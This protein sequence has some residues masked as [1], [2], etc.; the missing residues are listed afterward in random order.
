MIE[1]TTVIS[2]N[3]GVSQA[4]V[5]QVLSGK[6]YSSKTRA[7]V[8]IVLGLTDAQMRKRYP[9]AYKCTPPKKGKYSK[10]ALFG[11]VDGATAVMKA[12]SMS[13]VARRIG[14]SRT[15]LIRVLAGEIDSDRVMNG[16]VD[17]VTGVEKAVAFMKKAMKKIGM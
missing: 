14:C 8:Q 1:G 10:A 15:M 4:H 16:F 9:A 3:F 6:R 2:R 17:Y 13:E 5:Y 12:N 11:R 7:K